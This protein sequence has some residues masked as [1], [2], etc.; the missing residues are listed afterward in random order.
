MG[1]L[2][3]INTLN[4]A[5][6]LIGQELGFP[7]ATEIEFDINTATLY[8]EETNGN[9]NLHTLNPATGLS[10]GFVTHGCCALNGLEFVGNTLYATNV[11][12]GGGGTPSTLEIVNTGSGLLTP[13]GPT[14]ILNPITGLA[15]D[16]ST[17]TMYGVIGGGAPAQLVTINLGSGLA[18]PGPFLVDAATGAQLDRVGSIEFGSDGVLYGGMG[19]GATFNPGWLI[20]INPAN[21]SSNFIGPTGLMGITGLTN[22]VPEPTSMGLLGLALV[23][24]ALRRKRP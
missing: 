2:T 18:T 14:G 5:G 20:S 15:Y 23:M 19:L 8:S 11:M 24:C 3:S 12:A 21:G 13:I 1:N 16:T 10:T 4:G 9:V 22:A 17:N 7:L 6:V